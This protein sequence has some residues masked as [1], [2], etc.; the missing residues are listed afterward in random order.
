MSCAEWKVG[1]PGARL[2]GVEIVAAEDQHGN[3][4][5]PGVVD[6]HGRV[7]QADRAMDQRHDRFAGRLEVAVAH[8]DAGFFVR[9]GEEFRIVL[10]P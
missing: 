7:L 5:A 6:R 10:L 1:T 2:R 9:A 4:V 8:R 3:A